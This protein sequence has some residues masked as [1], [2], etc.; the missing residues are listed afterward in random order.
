[1]TQNAL[2]NKIIELSYV[3][4]YGD[5]L[6]DDITKELMS[7]FQSHIREVI[8]EDAAPHTDHSDKD[9]WYACIHCMENEPR[10]ELRAEQRLRA[11]L[12]E[13]TK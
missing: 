11:G 8:G 5:A 9:E 7:L 4:C 12:E 6:A 10:D 1:M 2:E 13:N 3:A